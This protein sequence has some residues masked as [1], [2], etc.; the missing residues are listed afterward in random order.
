MLTFGLDMLR[1][2]SPSAQVK[3]AA[4]RVQRLGRNQRKKKSSVIIVVISDDSYSL[5]LLTRIVGTA[6]LLRRY[7]PSP[8]PLLRLLSHVPAHLPVANY[9]RPI[10]RFLPCEICQLYSIILLLSLSTC[11]SPVSVSGPAEH[12]EILTLRLNYPAQESRYLSSFV[13]SL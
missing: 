5:L 7:S 1:D 10:I 2:I 6:A 9:N 8:H 4:A 13:Y 3:A 12:A 11:H